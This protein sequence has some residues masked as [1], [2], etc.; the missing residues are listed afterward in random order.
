[1]DPQAPRYVELARSGIILP[2][3]ITARGDGVLWQQSSGDRVTLVL[4]AESEAPIRWTSPSSGFLALE[5]TETRLLAA[6][7]V[8]VAV[9]GDEVDVVEVSPGSSSAATSPIARFRGIESLAATRDGAT[10]AVGGQQVVAGPMVVNVVGEVQWKQSF[11]TG[12]PAGIAIEAAGQMVLIRDGTTSSL[13]WLK[14]DGS[15]APSPAGDGPSSPSTFRT[16]APSPTPRPR[17]AILRSA[18]CIREPVLPSSPA[19][20][21][22]RLLEPAAPPARRIL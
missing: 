4:G 17:M 2:I 16:R 19:R 3:G 15:T 18:S 9:G 5:A 1:M 7:V 21:A 6:D 20:P 14:P 10:I 8:N 22:G 11:E 13:L 12:W